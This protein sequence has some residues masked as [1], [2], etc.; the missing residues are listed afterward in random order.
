MSNPSIISNSERNT[1]GRC[2]QRWAW[3]YLDNLASRQRPADALWFGVGVHEALAEW[4]QPGFERGTHPADYFEDWVG[5]EVRV[6]KASRADKDRE[7]FDEP[8]YE[9]AGELGVAMLTEYVNKYGNDRDLEILAI[10]QP[11][12]LELVRD[13]E[14]VALFIG[15]FDGVALDHRDKM[16]KLLEHKTASAIKTAHL[17]LDNQAGSYFAA[18]TVVLRW[19]GILEPKEAIEGIEYNF[20]R[21]SLPDQRKRNEHGAYLNKNGD[22]S[23]KQPPPPFVREFV[24]RGPREVRR[25]LERLTDEVIEMNMVRS[26]E[27]KVRKVINDTCPYCPFYTMCVMH[28]RGGKS[29][30]EYRDAQY[31]KREPSPLRKSASE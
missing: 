30:M 11:F 24:D 14:V 21:K 6:I 7:W 27:L 28:E 23:K 29:W 1:F 13:D 19:Q 12:E 20:L 9:D 8:L 18:A 22:I 4:Y 5:E 3:M 26:G 2:P 16:I 17:S 25:Q 31:S 10:E 15:V